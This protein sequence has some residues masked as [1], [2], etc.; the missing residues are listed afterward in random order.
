ME[1]ESV[2]K[3][4]NISTEKSS[5]IEEKS[6]TNSLK[7]PEETINIP[8]IETVS[9]E[10]QSTVTS[11]QPVTEDI[12]NDIPPAPNTSVQFYVGWKKV[13]SNPQLRYL[14]FKVR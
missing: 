4:S 7:E 14:Y 8:H 1:E 9:V 6:D 11:C 10:S 5:K 2:S 3:L 13:K 12:V